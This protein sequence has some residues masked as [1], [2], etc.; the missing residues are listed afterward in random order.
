MSRLW[1]VGFFTGCVFLFAACS[2]APKKAVAPAQRVGAV[3]SL[4]LPLLSEES[5]E[6]KKQVRIAI[7]DEMPP[8]QK[9]SRSTANAPMQMTPVSIAKD[10]KPRMMEPIKI[11]STRR[12]PAEAALIF[13]IPVAYNGKVKNWVQYFQGDGR[14]WF[15]KWLERSTRYMPT[16]QRILKQHGLPRDLAYMAMIESG[17]S[18]FASSH[19]SAVGPW[20]FIRETGNRYGLETTWW[21]DERRDF[22]KS[23]HAAAKYLKQMYG[24]FNNWYLVAAAY[25]TGENRIKRMTQKHNTKSFWKLA[26]QNALHDETEEYVPKMIAAMLISKSPQLYGFRNVSYQEIMDFEHFRVP[27]GTNLEKVADNLGVTTSYMRELNPELVRGYVPTHVEGHWIR[28]PK[29]SSQL[30]AR[31]I[32]RTFLSQN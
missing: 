6:N 16:I 22:E 26:Q 4:S 31:Y 28:I 12:K 24:M 23:S 11:A 14:K 8:P 27:G 7:I 2:S 5:Q 13:D 10:I 15:T 25:N 18:P 9:V 19:A 17:F 3:D 20:Q 32:R 29:G 21:L 30:M 1:K